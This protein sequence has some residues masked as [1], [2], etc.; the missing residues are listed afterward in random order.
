MEFCLK[1]TRKYSNNFD[2]EWKRDRKSERGITFYSV[3]NDSLY[4]VMTPYSQNKA[5]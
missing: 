4:D 1:K 3:I 5:L 2:S